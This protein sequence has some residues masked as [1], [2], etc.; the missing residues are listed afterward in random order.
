[1][2]CDEFVAE[3]QVQRVCEHVD[4]SQIVA[5]AHHCFDLRR[6]GFDVLDLI[7]DVDDLVTSVHMHNRA[8]HHQ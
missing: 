3:H 8:F 2:E 4:S 1:V 7:D 6:R 5:L